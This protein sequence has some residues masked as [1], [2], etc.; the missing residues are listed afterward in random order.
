[1][2]IKQLSYAMLLI[3]ATPIL[4][5]MEPR[6]FEHMPLEIKQNFIDSVI[7]ST[8]S[9]DVAISELK[10]IRL[11]NTELKNLVNSQATIR[12]LAKKNNLPLIIVAA[13]TKYIAP[14]ASQKIIDTWKK[15][16]SDRLKSKDEFQQ[17]KNLEINAIAVIPQTI[18]LIIAGKDVQSGL[19]FITKV[20]S[21]GN[22][23]KQFANN[24]SQTQQSVFK[25]I[26]VT[27][28]PGLIIGELKNV[29]PHGKPDLKPQEL[30]AVEIKINFVTNNFMDIFINE[31]RLSLNTLGNLD[32]ME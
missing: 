14:T 24:I 9:L 26:N 28:K 8:S 21:E 6:S 19:F 23:E 4:K 16:I 11:V 7:K 15:E 29:L 20:N 32:F 10:N 31:R 27:A 3:L 13:K 30:S 17:L 5:C 25:S 1:M 2:K 12:A 22:I 18:N